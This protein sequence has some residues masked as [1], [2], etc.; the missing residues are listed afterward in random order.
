MH[1]TSDDLAELQRLLDKSYESAGVH[2]RRIITL[3]RRVLAAH[4]GAS[5]SASRS[6]SRGRE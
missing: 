6:S 5:W 3:E 4:G 2:L 1:E